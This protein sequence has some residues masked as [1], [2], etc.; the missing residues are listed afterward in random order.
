MRVGTVL[1]VAAALVVAVVVAGVALLATLDVSKYRGLI[2][3]EAEKATGRD[4][5]L[6]GEIDLAIGLSPAIVVEDVALA[7]AEWGS[8][9]TMASIE[10][11]EAEIALIPALTGSVQ[12]NRIVLVKPNIL[13]ETAKDG[14]ANWDFTPLKEGTQTETAQTGTAPAET[15][16]DLALPALKAVSV[17]DAT[18]VYRDGVTGQVQALTIKDFTAEADA[19]DDPL[20]F[21]LEGVYNDVAFDLGGQ[22]GS[23]GR[24]GG[25]GGAPYPVVVKGEFGGIGL[26]VEGTVAEPLAARGLDLALEIDAPS[27][28]ALKPLAA[29]PDLPPITV[30]GRLTGSM[31]DSVTLAD[32][33]LTAGKSSGTGRVTAQLGGARPSVDVA[34]QAALVDLGELTGAG[35]DEAASGTDA[36]KTGA[37]KPK[38]TRVLPD[39]RLPFDQLTAAD[40]MFDVAVAKLILPDGVEVDGV[41]VKGALQNGRLTVDPA[42]ARLGDGG[43]A[44]RAVVT[45]GGA[46]DLDLA[47]DTVI[48][49]RLFEQI[50][51]PDL[52]TGV[53]TDAEIVLKGRGASVAAIAASLDGSILVK[54][55]EGRIHNALIDWAGADIANQLADALDPTTGGSETTALSCGV[56]NINAKDGVLGWDKQIAFETTKMNVVSS[57]GIN[58]GSEKLDVAVRPYAK[59][60]V[61]F[62]AGQL[63]ELIRIKGTLAKPEIV[64]D[65]E[66]VAKTALSI[67]GAMATGGASLLAQGAYDRMARDTTP[68]ATA[69][70]GQPTPASGDQ[71]APAEGEGT[72]GGALPQPVEA[73][74]KGLKSLFGE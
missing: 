16:G 17:K 38:G 15:P 33:K 53:P 54:M 35:G 1:K 36:G 45:A 31:D 19:L 39:D 11:L 46:V 21:V 63:A 25:G 2:E 37:G 49:G 42:K 56:L 3:A 28:E 8:Q 67:A 10:R 50:G 22:V 18:F 51:K 40:A 23:L 69:L 34:V 59:E 12:I 62:S 74:E 29:V 61:T 60:G 30:E 43:V 26:A 48:L 24:L 70:G 32:L 47:A 71:A 68:C 7:N 14:R 41:S 64:P 6:A 4:V 13:L 44:A 55:G 20:S 27:F 52:L 9:P 57:G 5:T 72:G 73:L 65:V 58:L 66:G